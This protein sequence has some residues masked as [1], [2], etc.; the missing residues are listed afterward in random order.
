MYDYHKKAIRITKMFRYVCPDGIFDEEDVE[1][2]LR[3]RGEPYTQKL[4]SE[5]ILHC[6]QKTVE[7]AMQELN[8]VSSDPLG[9]PSKKHIYKKQ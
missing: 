7:K 4:E 5:L 6:Q 9:A 2:K 1:Q 8:F 3:I